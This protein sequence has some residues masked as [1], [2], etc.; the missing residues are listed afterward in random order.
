MN[1][2]GSHESLSWKEVLSLLK[3]LSVPVLEM[4]DH[5]KILLVSE[6]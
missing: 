2:K 1:N 4:V 6:Y 3:L 5:E